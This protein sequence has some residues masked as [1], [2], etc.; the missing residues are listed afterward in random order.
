MALFRPF[1]AVIIILLCGL[2]F[3]SFVLFKGTSGARADVYLENEKVASF[4]LNNP[5]RIKE[6]DSQIGKIKIRVGNGSIQ[7]LESPC[8]QNICILRGAIQE[9]HEHITCLP[10]RMTISLIGKASEKNP[11]SS[12]DAVAY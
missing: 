2:T 7:V 4:E 9:T 11:F 5:D 10:A 1:D 8:N 12:V 6:I 3:G